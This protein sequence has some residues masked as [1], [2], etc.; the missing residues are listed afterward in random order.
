MATDPAYDLSSLS[1]M[2]VD[3]SYHMLRIVRT[4]LTA[5]N[6]RDLR[7]VDN[8]ADAVAELQARPPQLII[9]D[10]NMIPFDGL[11]FVRRVRRG[12]EATCPNVP[13]LLLT[14]HTERDRVLEARDCGVNRVMAKPISFRTLYDNIAAAMSDPRPFINT[15]EYVGP[16][17]RL[18]AQA[19][20]DGEK[21]RDQPDNDAL[22]SAQ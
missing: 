16:D 18:R 21:R 5:M 13:I 4:L 11:E 7:S 20:V 17:R 2:I 1:V 19:P 8:P 15:A 3:D 12:K 9:V 14:A 6:V 10:W 22:K